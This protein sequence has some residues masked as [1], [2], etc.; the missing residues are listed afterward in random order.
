MPNQVVLQKIFIE[1]LPEIKNKFR[2][3]AQ[4]YDAENY[5][6]IYKNEVSDIIERKVGESIYII[7]NQ[8]IVLSENV[9]IKLVHIS[10]KSGERLICRFGFHTSFLV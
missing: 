5:D 9:F 4:I 1:K 3:Q 10:K 2:V 6:L 7:F 8:E